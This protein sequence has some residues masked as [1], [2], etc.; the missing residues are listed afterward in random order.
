MTGYLADVNF[1]FA[2]V[3]GQHPHVGRAAIWLER[4]NA[5]DRITICRVVQMGVLRLLTKPS[6]MKDR[7]LSP[8][9]AWGYVHGITGD[10]RFVFGEEPPDFLES[11]HSVALGVPKGST[12]DTDAYLAAF[13]ISADLT[14]LTFDGGMI[15]F[16]GLR[17]A[18]PD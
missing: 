7:V 15:R 8:V 2:L 14:V 12:L 5:Q 10:S 13:A 18:V 9:D 11:W 1:V 3:H 4:L 6:V 17:V 16:P